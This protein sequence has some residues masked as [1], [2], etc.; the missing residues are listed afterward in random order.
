MPTCTIIV[1]EPG[2]P[3]AR[4]HAPAQ[5][6]IFTTVPGKPEECHDFACGPDHLAQELRLIAL[7]E[8]CDV[9]VQRYLSVP[10]PRGWVSVQA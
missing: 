7:Y 10:A 9:R 6:A 5:S 1:S 3:I 8:V 4:C 2:D